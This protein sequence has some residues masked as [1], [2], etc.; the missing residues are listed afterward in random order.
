[1]HA[2]LSHKQPSLQPQT[3]KNSL[4]KWDLKRWNP[5]L[6]HVKDDGTGTSRADKGFL[7]AG[8]KFWWKGIW[9]PNQKREW[10]NKK[11]RGSKPNFFYIGYFLI[12][13]IFSPHLVAWLQFCRGFGP[14]P[15]PPWSAPV[16]VQYHPANCL[17]IWWWQETLSKHVS[18]VE[19]PEKCR[20]NFH[21]N[22]FSIH[23]L[24]CV[25]F[26]I[27]SKLYLSRPECS[28]IDSYKLFCQY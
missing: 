26:N 10:K 19:K 13:R 5:G 23:L 4:T 2:F 28:L 21:S 1:M 18:K 27:Q 14:S 3:S 11:A 9:I 6:K 22:S 7:L 15:D 25:A 20:H 8:S 12:R 16:H 24:L 17:L